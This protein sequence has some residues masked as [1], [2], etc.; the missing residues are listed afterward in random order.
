[1]PISENPNQEGRC[2]WGE[3]LEEAQGVNPASSI[4]HRYKQL[5]VYIIKPSKYDDDG[6]VM[7]YWK[8]V[9]PSN[10]LACLYG[11][12]EDVRERGILGRN[13][14]WK[15]ELIDDTVQ[16]IPFKKIIHASRCKKTKV[17]VCLAGVQTNQIVRA[18]DLA[19]KFR[20]AGISVLLGGFHVSGVMATLPD[21][22]PELVT[23]KD[24]GVTLVGGE[25]EGGHWEVLLRDTILD[26]L[27][28]IYNFLNDLP[29]ISKAPFP[30]IHPKLLKHYAIRH[31]GTLDCGRGCPFGCSFCTVI[32]VQ[33]RRMRFRDA[34]LVI[35]KIREDYLRHGISHFFF[36]DDNFCR[37]KNWEAILDGMIELRE[38]EKLPVA[39]MMQLDTQ[40]HLVPNFV[41]KAARAG[42]LQVFIGMESLNQ[43]NLKA[44]KKTQNEIENFKHLVEAFQSKKIMCH[45]AYI[46]G[47]PLD[48]V[49]SV[50]VDL[51]QLMALGAAQAS[52]FMM[53]PI[54]GSMDYKNAL[55]RGMLMD[56]DLNNYDTFHETHRHPRMAPGEWLAAYEEAW[57]HFYGMENMKNVLRHTSAKNFWGVFFNFVWYK[58]SVEVEGG[59]PMLHGFVRFKPRMDRRIGYPV[60][61]RWAHF[62][63]RFQEVRAEWR[64][65]IRLALE[66]EELWL[67]TR[68]RGPLEEK[69][70]SEL[71]RLT[72][73]AK[74]WRDMRISELQNL[75]RKAALA[76]QKKGAAKI[77]IPS[78]FEI[79]CAKWNIFYDKLTF[80]R[81]PM[82]HFWYKVK[83]FLKEGK[84]F[85]IDYVRV[86]VTTFEEV[87]LFLRFVI[88]LL[89]SETF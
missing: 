17:L 75:Y 13:L 14:K 70:V 34:N 41:E 78:K 88:A 9:L 65:W 83:V 16:P 43:E 1:M 15:I 48:T 46:I 29:D 3:T 27:Q 7:R 44:A 37:N 55:A 21:L 47:F 5:C 4:L 85:E 11:L 80:T 71:A 40:S 56:A 31:F 60:E 49:T 73:Y 61:T 30:R 28:P 12:T 58:N 33:G 42:C 79:F 20:K 26:T 69:V 50:K 18:S 39:C 57:K 84:L 76:L 32:N 68:H 62:K 67:A 89:R 36:T 74:E 66:L 23:L 72:Q 25:G 54:P 77:R 59:H 52:F 53:T 81:M 51:Q 8:G 6:Y 10:T 45:L 86:V 35:N 22:S 38:K 87:V 63:K 64:G 24:A 82:R 2:P 19:L